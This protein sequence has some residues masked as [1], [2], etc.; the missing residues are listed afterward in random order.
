M[1]C[2]FVLTFGMKQKRRGRKWDLALC[3]C[4]VTAPCSAWPR[5]FSPGFGALG[6]L[7]AGNAQ[8]ILL[9]T[10]SK[11]KISVSIHRSTCTPFWPSTPQK[12]GAACLKLQEQYCNISSDKGF[13]S[14]SDT[15]FDLCWTVPCWLY[16][17][18]DD[19][20]KNCHKE[21]PAG[22]NEDPLCLQAQER[23]GGKACVW[24]Q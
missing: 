16:F 11:A 21:R 15:V 20:K 19:R 7:E 2:L 4:L 17:R 24:S 8:H 22:R 12:S 1:V 13:C 18:G 23:V 6:N 5:E 10:S 3:S 9:A 14:S